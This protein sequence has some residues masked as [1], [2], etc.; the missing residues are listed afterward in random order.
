MVVSC[1]VLCQNC[2][3]ETVYVKG[4]INFCFF[5]DYQIKLDR[6]MEDLV[7]ALN[8]YR[9]NTVAS[10]V[11]HLCSFDNG[12]RHYPWV[13]I[14]EESVALAEKVI[15]DYNSTLNDS[16][17]EWRVEVQKTLHGWKRFIVPNNKNR[18]TKEL[19]K[20]I[21]PLAIYIASI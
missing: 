1:V 9:I 14:E 18:G 12:S 7:I 4:E 21:L 10:C 13:L 20:N 8:N 16:Y 3:E 11:G 2:N 15:S 19:Q 6:T 5:C 17:K